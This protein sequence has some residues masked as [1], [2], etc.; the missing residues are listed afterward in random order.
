MHDGTTT[1]WVYRPI[2]LPPSGFAFEIADV[3]EAATGP[4]RETGGSTQDRAT[5][6][7]HPESLIEADQP[8]FAPWGRPDIVRWSAI[9][10]IAIFV[11]ALATVQF[12]AWWL[13]GVV[14]SCAFWAFMVL[15]FR[16]PK[17]AAPT[18][19][20]LLISP[21]DGTIWDIEEVDEDE[22]IGERCLRIGIFLS[23]FNVHVNRAPFD[24]K[25]TGVVY[26]PGLFRDARS[27]AA[28]QENES[29]TLRLEITE[30]ERAGC[31]VLV[32][33]VSGAIA[34]RIVCDLEEDQLVERGKLIGMIKYG[35]RT[36]LWI[37]VRAGFES[38]VKVG[39]KVQGGRSIIGR[40]V[41]GASSGSSES[42]ESSGAEE[43]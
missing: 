7:R 37:P 29:K 19:P 1:S 32:R 33:L 41:D 43:S 15:F 2:F 3:S 25:V 40:F 16:N 10:C 8:C 11:F 24:A 28:G 18:D 4:A 27:A 5:V 9:S 12:G 30:A 35:S 20:G 23:V 22:L 13:I 14:P 17:R 42:S 39:D 6:P 26:R 38:S 36:E 34:R 31:P 21:A